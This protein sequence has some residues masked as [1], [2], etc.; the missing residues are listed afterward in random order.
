MTTNE[1][2]RRIEKLLKR[3]KRR[4]ERSRKRGRG[5]YG[6]YI[7]LEE[8]YAVVAKWREIPGTAAKMR[9]A[10]ADYAKVA[11]THVFHVLVAATSNEPKRTQSRWGQALRYAW[12]YRQQRTHLSLE[13]F[14]RNN[15]GPA[16]CARNLSEAIKPNL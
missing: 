14:F 11:N 16:G 12:R 3:L 10:I 13:K 8:I 15:G 4:H 7:Y 2:T 6:F 9:N 1:L 5:R